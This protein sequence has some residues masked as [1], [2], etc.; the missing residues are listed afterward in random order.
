MIVKTPN[1]VGIKDHNTN[2][3]QVKGNLP[4]GGDI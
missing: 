3:V 4:R 1:T 2:E